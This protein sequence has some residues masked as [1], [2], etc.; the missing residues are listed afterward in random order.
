M[1]VVMVMGICVPST[2]YATDASTQQ[3]QGASAQS[4]DQTQEASAQ[5]DDSSAQPAAQADVAADTGQ[6]DATSQSDA[7]ATSTDSSKTESAATTAGSAASG[8]T[9]TDKAESTYTVTLSATDG[10]TF[11][12]DAIDGVTFNKD[13]TQATIKVTAGETLADSFK[14]DTLPQLVFPDNAQLGAWAYSAD[15]GLQELTV[16]QLLSMKITRD[17]TFETELVPVEDDEAT[18]M[19][20][21]VIYWNPS[22]HDIK[23]PADDTVLAPKGD[24]AN[25]GVSAKY[26][27][28]T[29]DRVKEI[30]EG[31]TGYTV[32]IM[33]TAVLGTE[34]TGGGYIV[35]LDLNIN[36]KNGATDYNVTFTTWDQN[37]EE[38]FLIPSYDA[39]TTPATE[40]GSLTVANVTFSPASSTMNS[41]RIIGGNSTDGA[42]AAGGQL[43]IG[44]SFKTTSPIQYELNEYGLSLADTDPD[45]AAIYNPLVLDAQGSSV[46]QTYTIYYSGING[47]MFYQYANVV[48]AG[49]NG[50]ADMYGQEYFV[51][52]ARNE[53]FHWNYYYDGESMH[54]TDETQW[55]KSKLELSVDYRYSA[56]YVNPTVATSSFG[57]SCKYP[58]KT[59]EEALNIVENSSWEDAVD[60]VIYICGT[61]DVNNNTSWDLSHARDAY[62]TKVYVCS[63]PL[64]NDAHVHSVPTTLFNVASGVRLNITGMDVFYNLSTDYNDTTLT[65]TIF[66]VNPGASLKV[67]DTN[68]SGKTDEGSMSQGWGVK[69]AG[70]ST[71]NTSFTMDG[72]SSISY[73]SRGIQAVGV[74]SDKTK[75]TITLNG[76]SVSHNDLRIGSNSTEPV[77]GYTGGAGVY[78][79]NA[80]LDIAGGSIDDNTVTGTYYNGYRYLYGAG[81]YA[82]ATDI[83]MSDGSASRNSAGSYSTGGAFYMTGG[84]DFTMSGGT[85]DGNSSTSSSYPDGAGSALYYTNNGAVSISGGTVSNNTQAA[86]G[87]IYL[88]S[89]TNT[90]A[91]G[92]AVFSGNKSTNYNSSSAGAVYCSTYTTVTVDGATFKS[93]SASSGSSGNGGAIYCSGSGSQLTVKNT[94]FTGNS[95]G[96]NGGAIYAYSPDFSRPTSIENCTFDGNSCAS[97]GVGAAVYSGGAA[98]TVLSCEFMNQTGYN[99]SLYASANSTDV[100]DCNFHDNNVTNGAGVFASGSTSIVGTTFKDNSAT[101]GGGVYSN[102][103]VKICDSTFSG[104]SAS[105][106]G[107]GLCVNSGSVYVYQSGETGISTSFSGNSANYG[108]GVSNGSSYSA[109]GAGTLYLE[110]GTFADNTATL[111]GATLYNCGTVWMEGGTYSHAA[112]TDNAIYNDV[113]YSSLGNKFYLDPTKVTF[114]NDA[115][116][117]N[118]APS[119]VWLLKDPG[120]STFP[121]SVNT[122]NFKTGSVVVTPS[123]AVSHSDHDGSSVSYSEIDVHT[124][125]TNFQGG[126]LPTGATIQGY[127][128]NLI[129]GGQGVFLDGTNGDDANSGAD[130]LHPVKTWMQANANLRTNIAVA[131]AAGTTF[132]PYIYVVGTVPIAEDTTWTL[133]PDDATLTQ[134]AKAYDADWYPQVQRFDSYFGS[135]VNV[136]AGKLTLDTITINGKAEGCSPTNNTDSQTGG[137]VDPL[138]T[139]QTGATLDLAK[140]S[141]VSNNYQYGIRAYGATI[142]MTDD[143]FVGNNRNTAIYAQDGTAVNMTDSAQ[144]DIGPSYATNASDVASR[145]G[146]KLV[147]T[148][149]KDST[150]E[151][152]GTSHIECYGLIGVDAGSYSQA[153]IGSA[154]DTADSHPYIETQNG[155]NI[156]SYENK[157]AIVGSNDSKV[158][159]QG[160][161]QI[162]PSAEPDAGTRS[163]YGYVSQASSNDSAHPSTFTMTDHA[164]MINLTAGLHTYGSYYL[165]STVQGSAQIT[166]C[167]YGL[168][169]DNG[170]ND[171]FVFADDSSISCTDDNPD[172]AYGVY[173]RYSSSNNTVTFKDKASLVDLNSGIWASYSSYTQSGWKVSFED[174]SVINNMKNYG[175]YLGSYTSKWDISFSGSAG[176]DTCGSYGISLAGIGGSSYGQHSVTFG[177]DSYITDCSG[178]DFYDYSTG[179]YL[180]MNDNAVFRGGTPSE[181]KMQNALVYVYYNTS[182]T[183]RPGSFTMNDKS[184]VEG[185]HCYLDTD[186]AYRASYGRGV[187]LYVNDQVSYSMSMN[188]SATIK[189]NFGTGLYLNS[190]YTGYSGTLSASLYDNASI[191]GNGYQGLYVGGY[192]EESTAKTKA[193]LAAGVTVSGN[194]ASYAET[195]LQ[196]REIYNAGSLTMDIAA[197]VENEIYLPYPGHIIT[198][199][200]AD[201]VGSEGAAA[202]KFKIGY[203][204]NF[205]AQRVVEP[206]DS[207]SD[208]SQYL[209]SFTESTNVP[210]GCK[211]VAGAGTDANCIVVQ[212]GNAVFLAGDSSS[213]YS[214]SGAY[215]NDSNNGLS[216]S[217]PVRTFAR[218]KEVLAT[219]PQGSN[220][221]I[222]NHYVD[223]T[224]A[225]TTLTT[226]GKDL[227]WSFDA[228][229]TFTNASGETWTPR[230][231]AYSSLNTP[232][233]VF[234]GTLSALQR[235]DFSNLTFEANTGTTQYTYNFIEGRA[236]SQKALITGCTFIH[237]RQNAVSVSNSNSTITVDNCDFS[238]FAVMQTDVSYLDPCLANNSFLNCSS[239]ALNVANCDFSGFDIPAYSFRFIASGGK[240]SVADCSF[241]D[242]AFSGQ[243]YKEWNDGEAQYSGALVSSSG[244]ATISNVSMDGNSFDLEYG[245]KPGVTFIGSNLS[246]ALL[247]LTGTSTVSNSTVD[248]NSVKLRATSGDENLYASGTL[249][250]L[251][252]MGTGTMTDCSI[253]NN[254]ASGGTYIQ[255]VGLYS[256]GGLSTLTNC[257]IDNNKVVQSDISQTGWPLDTDS[258]AGGGIYVSR[259]SNA[260]VIMLSGSISNNVSLKGSA[261]YIDGT[262]DSSYNAGSLTMGGGSVSGNSNYDGSATAYEGSPIYD[263]GNLTI[264]GGRSAIADHIYLTSVDHPITLAGAIYQK[265]RIYNVDCNTDS[266]AGDARFKKGSVVV[267]PDGDVLDSATSYLRYFNVAATGFVLAKQQPNL[268]LKSYVFLDSVNGSDSNDG[269]NPDSAFKTLQGAFDMLTARDGDIT[270]TIFYISGPM[271]ITS[272][273]TWSLE[274]SRDPDTGDLTSEF[275]RYTGFSLT[276]G[277]TWPAYTGNL[278]DVADGATLSIDN[279][280]VNGRRDTDDTQGEAL[281]KV[282]KGGTVKLNAGTTLT[283][284]TNTDSPLSGKG[285]AILNSG[286]VNVGNGVTI[287]ETKATQGGGIYSTSDGTNAGVINVRG[288]TASIVP[289]VY[290]EGTGTSRNNPGLDAVVNAAV[291][292]APASKTQLSIVLQN[293]YEGRPVVDYPDSYTPNLVD[294]QKYHLES[295]VAS[296]YRLGNRA[297][298]SDILELQLKGVIYIDGQNG[299]DSYGGTTPDTAVKT[300]KHAYELLKLRELQDPDGNGGGVLMVVDTVDVS[301]DIQLINTPGSASVKDISQYIDVNDASQNVETA[302]TVYIR[303]YSQPTAHASME[304]FTHASNVNALVNV[305][306]GGTLTM[307]DFGVQG[308]SETVE[309]SDT[310][311]AA[312]G[313]QAESALITVQ[314]GGTFD[315]NWCEFTDNDNA[316]TGGQGGAVYVGNDLVNGNGSVTLRNAT[317]SNTSAEQG[318]ALYNNGKLAFDSNMDITGSIYL[319]GTG[320]EAQPATSHYIDILASGTTNASG[321]YDVEVQD[322]YRTRTIADYPETATNAERASYNFQSNVTDY[323]VLRNRGTDDTVLELQFKSAIYIDGIHGDDANDGKTADTAVKTLKQAYTLLE[324]TESSYLYV[325][326]AVTTTADT[327]LTTTSYSDGNGD[328]VTLTVNPIEVYRYAQPTAHASLTGFTHETNT[329]ALF[330]SAGG[331]LTLGDL[332]VNGHSNAITGVNY[333]DSR[334]AA[335]AQAKSALLRTEEHGTLQ[336]E[337]GAVLRDNDNVS[338]ATDDASMQGGAVNNEGSFFFNQAMLINNKAVHGAAVYQDGNQFVIESMAADAIGTQGI[339]LTATTGS[340]AV[341]H[342]ISINGDE[343][344]AEVT[345]DNALQVDMDNAV[346]GRNVVVYSDGSY[347]GEL[348]DQ[349]SHYAVG[350]TVPDNLPLVVSKT[351]TNTLELMNYLVTYYDNGSTSG[352]VP[353]DASSPYVPGATATVLGNTGDLSKDNATFVGWNTKAD[354]TGTH[355]DADDTQVM[356][357]DLDL[358]AMWLG[359]QKTAAQTEENILRPGQVLTYTVTATV[360]EAATSVTITDVVPTGTAYVQDS[361]TQ[362]GTYKNG[363]ITWKTGSM[364][365]GETFTAEFKVTVPDDAAIGTEVSNTAKVAVGTN[366]LD[367]N[368]TI[369]TVGETHKV[370]YHGNGSTSGTVPAD[371]TH[372]AVGESATVLGNTGSLVKTAATFAGWNTKADGTGTHYVAGD[373]VTVA[374]DQV[375]LYA[376]W[377]GGTKSVSQ[378]ETTL[379]PG[380]ELT[381]TIDITVPEAST[382]VTATDTLPTGTTYVTGSA[383][384]GGTY[385]DGIVTWNLGA[386]TAGQT[387]TLSFKVTVDQNAAEGTQIDNKA[388]FTVGDN[389]YTSTTATS[390]VGV[391]FATHY[392]ANGATSGT[393][394]VDSNKYPRGATVTVSGNTGNL[395]KDGSVFAGWNTKADGTGT[396]YAA[397]S[398][399]V[400]E[401][402]VTLYAQWLSAG[403]KVGAKA[404]STSKLYPGKEIAYTITVGDVP[405]GATSAVVTDVLASTLT[406]VDGSASDGGT[407]DAA[408]RTITWDVTGKA[409]GCKLTFRAQVASSA[410]AGSTISNTATTTATVGD[411]TYSATTDPDNQTVDTTPALPSIEKSTEARNIS[412]GQEVVY[413]IVA[414]NTSSEK[415]ARGLVRDYVPENTTFVSCSDGGAYNAAT[416]AVTWLVPELASKDTYEMTLT[417]KVAD[418]LAADASVSNVAAVG[419][420]EDLPTDPTADDLNNAGDP[421]AQ[422]SN[423]VTTAQAGATPAASTGTKAATAATA[424]TADGTA[425]YVIVMLIVGAVA[426]A[427]LMVSRRKRRNGCR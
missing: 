383:D 399:Y 94:S 365:A 162:R 3:A 286:T 280:T 207:V 290:L 145:S 208:A 222:C 58:V 2:S 72:E 150:L 189:D 110:G 188:D 313:V 265:N 174:Q 305:K 401:G 181:S 214:G 18:T 391:V 183:R 53:G 157:G 39:S 220:I 205:I 352:A 279:A 184:S 95:S 10:A 192:R 202:D 297:T 315:C 66:N 236:N 179:T 129:L 243:Y 281:I 43:T 151:M 102:S 277:Y 331:T 196:G 68:I 293:A 392:E 232:M 136:T 353:V 180:T 79:A 106:C 379:L 228:D 4:T 425:P 25:S 161:A 171:T 21:K 107:G 411:T 187:Y 259:G 415:S 20:D 115:F 357:E 334:I 23:D 427:M 370:V 163:G 335:G 298:A 416:G 245:D 278:F 42:N 104:N 124:F 266:S 70:S 283:L 7:A 144:L 314:G 108:G 96:G 168:L 394:P 324:S 141:K 341:N 31:S 424:K 160:Y 248:G 49:A 255:G 219:L 289:E 122:D 127:S 247:S 139:V 52:S 226:S 256:Y 209:G 14:A 419:P 167:Q 33:A 176:I 301:S 242:N 131:N 359:A 389:A 97:S 223:P 257:T 83:T 390:T 101:N 360:P 224:T 262:I 212:S 225:T 215:G 321:K 59:M 371:A 185:A 395:A 227:D 361:A 275:V 322:P 203:D 251:V 382:A 418:D 282:E 355:Y 375:D 230:L 342:V 323:Y 407:Y 123:G 197:T 26:P 82:S 75:T 41:I 177:G 201:S 90:L 112:A 92:E 78:A 332:V 170:S 396:S 426:V 423:K 273:E 309:S 15:D 38:L 381:Y 364:A 117:L 252:R 154:A 190:I 408:T 88:T 363:T 87:A 34:K 250:G 156:T 386:A 91:I 74:G 233:V 47:N 62:R 318:S 128:T 294:A 159:M 46:P 54:P 213:Y 210:D 158:L 194:A 241:D 17:I 403:T 105:N 28:L 303:R 111:G 264:K 193:S 263:N 351:E 374:N 100:T 204:N 77:V 285:G 12:T 147:G 413:K 310:R 206:S 186:E 402:D 421:T 274:G 304:G 272:D 326:D 89:S 356:N 385:A 50:P 316:E 387:F 69:I 29:W 32:H 114:L 84:G 109:T 11:A 366:S 339:Y 320:S 380:Q 191:T 295:S 376:M 328:S 30:Y 377:V 422:K 64:I 146:I 22:E 48:Q 142:N 195:A 307:S 333:P 388:Q 317:V 345:G 164:S 221:I 404:D 125:P 120:T 61:I 67:T 93:N 166:N 9:A 169:T 358:Y 410:T 200:D 327:S 372:Y 155:S 368:T 300:F 138:I 319:A 140:G 134:T 244:T 172:S 414:T 239:G 369:N 85:I 400:A 347:S 16:D 412:A 73:N 116:F 268:V 306:A 55:D 348:A 133:D 258:T 234:T 19:A 173:A 178:Y 291:N 24:D 267:K 13:A 175:I 27:V 343:I 261:A 253:S 229:G 36:G 76:G 44:E 288:T 119:K 420:A 45:T 1:S 113:S 254:T 350:S 149:Q 217:T 153:T 71:A 367:S 373:T 299:D 86:Y 56:V 99:G 362:G 37:E 312:P 344:P 378:P 338:A 231:V 393:V 135:L 296:L 406:Y 308:H 340:S 60:R 246:G 405:A 8:S 81:V 6:A 51:L 143:A 349:L 287:S 240:L 218:A 63:S 165:T 121:L 80:T 126:T 276:G 199:T 137:G 397:D 57:G 354:G 118:T 271:N 132:E 35:P 65:H 284:N 211:M 260:G 384:E 311:F 249:Q 302:G 198:L 238:D 292:Y 337:S 40:A 336:L 98:T 148:A 329:G 330:D 269:S 216:P 152:Q 398:T 270:N 182:S 237:G 130:P 325:V 103:T 5:A 235:V 409:A 346:R 417:V